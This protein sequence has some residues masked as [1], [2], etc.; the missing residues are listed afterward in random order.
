MLMSRPRLQSRRG[1]TLVELLITIVLLGLVMGTLLNVILRQQRFYHAASEIIDTRSQV[2]QAS[3][4]LPADL[5]GAST[6]AGAVGGVIVADLYAAGMLRHSISY[7]SSFGS[8]VACVI[9]AG[10]TR[11]TVPPLGLASGNTL[12]SWLR[13]PVA[14]DSIF[15]FDD[16]GV[17]GGPGAWVPREIA[18]VE[19]MP[20]ACPNATGFTEAADAGK[21]AWVITLTQALPG[22][23]P[24]G[25]GAGTPVRFFLP[26][27]Y[28]LYQAADGHWYL[29]YGDCRPNRVPVCSVLE[30]VSGPYLPPSDD[31]ALSGVTFEYLDGAGVPVALPQDVATIRMTFRGETR[32]AVKV[33]GMTT[34]DDGKFR[35]GMTVTVAVRNRS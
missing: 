6:A 15:V 28:E 8:A 26:V 27:T 35:D 1:F 3:D 21:D 31:P 11:I 29:G 22:T 24:T 4:L 13:T 25:V 33:Q 17:M 9:D 5:R 19:P 34:T 30:P 23:V 14:G 7:R 12:T 2:R 18:F 20:D 32:S 16:Q 10:R